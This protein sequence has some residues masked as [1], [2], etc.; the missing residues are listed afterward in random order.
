MA[1]YFRL[2]LAASMEYRVSF[3]AQAA[4]MVA[5]DALAFFFWW[6][7]FQNFEDV[8]GW[9]LQDLVLLWAIVASSVGLTLILFANAQR[10]S[11]V[12]SQGQLDY[13]L[14]LP[15]HPLLHV[16]VSRMNLA[17]WG[18]L[19][20][21]LAA[22]ALAWWMGILFVPLAIVL[23]LLSMAVGV[24]F[25][26]LVGSLAFFIGSAEAAAVRARDNLILFSTYPGSIFQGWAKLLLLTVIPA[27]FM[28]HL[29]VELLREFDPAKM[30]LL[31]AFTAAL[32]LITI[33]VFQVGLRRYESGN[34]IS[35]RG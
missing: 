8:G 17:G 11:T 2:N 19:G 33:A 6:V 18:D 3:F 22:A 28:A 7:Y 31:V 4:G 9:T 26:V 1:A 34:L 32:W 14:A 25:V 24:A 12:I 35:L 23:I 10:L 30:A 21:G 13:Y 15:H 27:G 20:F 16:L 5:N 29:P